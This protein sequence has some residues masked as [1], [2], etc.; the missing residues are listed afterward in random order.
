M[1][2]TTDS[3]SEYQENACLLSIHPYV[4][5]AISNSEYPLSLQ[6]KSE[7]DVYLMKLNVT[8]KR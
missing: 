6:K 2:Q 3:K 5:K 4:L 1:Y 7:M 8:V